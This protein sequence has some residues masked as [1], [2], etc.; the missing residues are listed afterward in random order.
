[1]PR[2]QRESS[3]LLKRGVSCHYWQTFFDRRLEVSEKRRREG[4]FNSGLQHGFVLGCHLSHGVTSQGWD[5]CDSEFEEGFVSHEIKVILAY[6]ILVGLHKKYSVRYI[7]YSSFTCWKSIGFNT[8]E[9]PAPHVSGMTRFRDSSNVIRACSLSLCFLARSAHL[10]GLTY[11]GVSSWWP[12]KALGLYL[13]VQEK[14]KREHF[15]SDHSGRRLRICHMLFLEPVTT[16]MEI[17]SSDWL[18]PGHGPH[19]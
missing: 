2:E 14:E 18:G 5:L 16:A 17:C 4:R 9:V 8:L 11:T 10:L 6:L 7:N 19:E 15:S 1:M 3:R 12:L 13:L